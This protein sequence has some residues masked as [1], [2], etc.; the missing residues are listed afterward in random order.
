MP[1][2]EGRKAPDF[3]LNDQSGK[4]VKLSGFAKKKNV[5]I[6]FYPRDDTPGCTTEACNF[7]DDYYR[8]KALG[9]AV[10]GVS[11]DDS[12]SHE[13]FAEKYSLPFPLLANSS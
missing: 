7:R 9:A 4:P 6:Y 12:E 10:V 5:L 1:I 8:L 11:L 2:Q 13:E 3:T